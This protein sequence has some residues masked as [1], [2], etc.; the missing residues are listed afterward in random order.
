MLSAHLPTLDAIVPVQAEVAS[1]VADD[2]NLAAEIAV[3]GSTT[4]S[5]IAVEG[6][7]IDS[8]VSADNGT[9]SLTD[10]L[11]SLPVTVEKSPS[12]KHLELSARQVPQSSQQYLENDVDQVV[13][14]EQ[15][16]A[17]VIPPI[18]MANSS[19]V[20]Q[21][22]QLNQP[23]SSI[24]QHRI[25]TPHDRH[26]TSFLSREVKDPVIDLEARVVKDQVTALSNECDTLRLQN[27]QLQHKL[28]DALKKRQRT[29]ELAADTSDSRLGQ[30]IEQRYNASL[31]ALE[32]RKV[33]LE[34]TARA[35]SLQLVD[36]QVKFDEKR[37]NV[38]AKELELK[39]MKQAVMLMSENS[40][41]GKLISP[42]VC[43]P[44]KAQY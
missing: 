30:N 7:A 38:T 39:K 9:L 16:T 40:K 31:L 3:E 10:A 43:S 22:A 32:Q 20:D 36:L 34:E 41:T 25:S 24:H 8:E 27:L 15:D 44:H 35:H 14:Q 18:E 13:S 17:P 19:D 12:V 26:S 23:E 42:H 29:E 11:P 2:L 5:R 33:S 4:D 21:T 1:I 6:S 37:Q 28:S